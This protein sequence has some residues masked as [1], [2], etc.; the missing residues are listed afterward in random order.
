ML[1]IISHDHIAPWL[2]HEGYELFHNG[3]WRILFYEFNAHSQDDASF[4]SHGK[5][6]ATPCQIPFQC[7]VLSSIMKTTPLQ[8]LSGSFLMIRPAQTQEGIKSVFF[9]F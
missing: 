1:Y 2:P 4:S 8:H 6:A 3:I 5:K 9:Y 7:F